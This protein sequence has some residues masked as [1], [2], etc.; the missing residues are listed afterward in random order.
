MDVAIMIK[1]NRRKFCECGCGQR[2]RKRFVNN[3]HANK[4]KS[5]PEDVKQKISKTLMHHIVTQET[6][7]KIRKALIGRKGFHH[8]EET[9]RKISLLRK[10]KPSARIGYKHSEET[11]RKIGIGNKGKKQ[12]CVSAFKGKKHSEETKSKI[13]SRLKGR[14]SPR[15]GVSLSLETKKKIS[16]NGKK[17]WEDPNYRNKQMEIRNKKEYKEKISKTM[18]S[19]MKILW[20]DQSYKDKQL[21]LIYSSMNIH[22]NKPEAIILNL[23]DKNYPNEWKFAGDFSCIING[24]SPDFVN[25]KQKKIIELFGDY[26]HKG[27]NP[28][29]RENIF[30]PFGYRTLIIWENELKNLNKVSSK[31]KKFHIL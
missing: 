13:S 6:R 20:K 19:A 23:L 25:K 31:I 26:W 11:K 15:K 18:S 16:I 12:G 29:D 21:K 14:V 5:Q 4:G 9:K 2:V 27:Q 24:K 28:K 3:G 10:N 1:L 30:K 22:P 17:H 8:S 7:N